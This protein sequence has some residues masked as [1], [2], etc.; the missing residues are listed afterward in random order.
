[1]VVYSVKKTGPRPFAPTCAAVAPKQAYWLFL[2]FA[3]YGP[4][5]NFIGQFR[6]VEI[7]VLTLLALNLH[8]AFRY[9]GKWEKLFAGLFLLT[10][11]AQVISDLVN[12]ASIEGTLK[13]SFTYVILAFLLIS[14]RCLSR[15]DPMRLRWILAGYCLSYATALFLGNAASRNYEIAAWRLGLGTAVT[16]AICLIPLWV[17]RLYRFVGPALI[18]MSVIHISSGARALAV[19]VAV[20]GV[21]STVAAWTK[22]PA[23]PPR[24]QPM[25]AVKV[26]LF[27]AVGIY[28]VY[29]SSLWATQAGLFPEE[30]QQ[31]MELQ[32][33]NP[34]GILAAGRPDTAAALYGVTKAPFLGFGST[35]VDPD[36]YAFYLDIANST[37]VWSEDFADLQ[38]RAWARE[39]TLGTPSHSHLLGA[40]VDAGVFGALSWATFFGLAIY[41]L[42]RTAAWHHSAQPLIVLVAEFVLWDTLFSPG[43]HRMDVAL[44]LAV[45]IYGVELLHAADA[46]TRSGFGALRYPTSKP[47]GGLS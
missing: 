18:A 25:R 23:P 13:R 7:V 6:Y 26:A 47:R 11:F 46:V 3:F 17:P 9:V 29:Q 10:A 28:G 1:M 44:R 14:V 41:L 24:F 40:W 8:R 43:P 21:L 5:I 30:I 45:L 32:F 38:A 22:R 36:V 27:G 2:L 19:L 33:S 39:W 42:Q 15:G 20:A 37:Y 12:D 35:N 31:K 16:I 4:S 34:Y